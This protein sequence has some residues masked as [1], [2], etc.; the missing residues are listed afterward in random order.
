MT[1]DAPPGYGLTVLE[2]LVVLAVLAA[3]AWLLA[4]VVFRYLDDSDAPRAITYV[5][6]IDATGGDAAGMM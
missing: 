4:P 2:A 3:L 5:N 6:A 1:D